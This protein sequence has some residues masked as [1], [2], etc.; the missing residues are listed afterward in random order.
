MKRE[1]KILL[2]EDSDGDI[3]LITQALK[4]AQVTNGVTVIKDGDKALLYLRKEGDYENVETPDLILLDI[5]LP[6]VD[7]IEVLAEIKN[8]PLLMSIPV[9]MLTTSESEKDVINSYNNHANCYI[10]KPVNFQKFID[11][12]QLIKEFWIT[13]VKLPKH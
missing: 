9:V 10:V 7:G 12:V 13:I 4:K 8:D 1:V 2:I 3:L 5:N 11:V 6:R